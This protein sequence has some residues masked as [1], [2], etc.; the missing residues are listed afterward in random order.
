M[1]IPQTI[2]IVYV[3]NAH[4]AYMYLYLKPKQFVVLLAVVTRGSSP[5]YHVDINILFTCAFTSSYN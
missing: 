4:V 3:T 2:D 1:N 5:V